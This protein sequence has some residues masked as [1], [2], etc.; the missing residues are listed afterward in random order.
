MKKKII[1]C[2]AILLLI[3]PVLA[4]ADQGS[5]GVEPS[6]TE[7]SGATENMPFP[8][9]AKNTVFKAE[10]LKILDAREEHNENGQIYRQQNVLL[11]ALD[12][13][14]RGQEVTY[15]GI[16]DIDVL[17]SI[18]VK[19]G[20]KVFILASPSIDGTTQY[21]ITDHV[22][23]GNL[24]VLTII[25]VLL[26]LWVGKKHGAK[27]L[28]ALILSF[29]IIM[30]LIIP[31]ILR[32]YNPVA[33]AVIG[34]VIILAVI[35][36][37]TWGWTQKAHIAMLSIVL[38]LIVTGIAS[39]FFTAMTK[40]SGTASED[41]MSLLSIGTFTVDFKGLLLA[42]MILGTVGVLDDV[43][44]SQISAV[45]QLKEANPNLSRRELIKSSSKIGIDH[46]SSMTNTLFLAYAGA[47]LPLLL[48]FFVRQEP[49]LTFSQIINNEMISTEIVRTLVGS[50]CLTL[51]VPISTFIAVYFLKGN[52]ITSN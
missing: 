26:I 38:S 43:I 37:L 47:A 24:L 2:I 45:E 51:A 27:S 29:A 17:S 40:L 22:R 46:L 1:T 18:Y 23:S 7:V 8:D 49:F 42:G 35:I 21:Y 15:Y 32:G 28:I 10:V 36:Y 34:S 31:L 16:G 30:M 25:F 48:I 13:D 50:I 33:I 12:G 19:P 20:N 52:K 9:L 5:D 41:I 44:I 39:W 3:F 14:L 6:L 11:K 4:L